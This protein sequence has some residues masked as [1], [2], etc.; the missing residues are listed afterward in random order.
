MDSHAGIVL[1]GGRSTRMG[2]PKASLEWH[3]STLVR[4]VAG[5]VARGVGGPVVVV[6]A[7]R[8][9]L[10][11]LP[12]TFEVVEDAEE[13]LGPL[14]GLSAGLQALGGRSDVA[15]VSSTDV[16]MLHPAFVRR[17]VSEVTDQ[18]D[19]CVPY[20]RGFRQPLSGAYRV[21]LAPL[22]AALV[23]ASRLRPAD[24]LEACRWTQLGD[25]AL[26]ADLELRRLDPE[27]DSVTN[28]NDRS[29]YEAARRKPAPEVSV[30]LSDSLRQAGST[31]LV[32]TRAATLGGATE[33]MRLQLGPLVVAT[34]NGVVVACDPELPLVRG[35]VLALSTSKG[36]PQGLARVT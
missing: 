20:V 27:L 35:D 18:F 6:R 2:Y 33:A 12:D 17:V 30:E 9:P 11:R 22:V 3:G 1:A 25:E 29:D 31:A 16:P 7:P 34:L 19:A 24:L 15:Y 36:G 28:L 4:R 21:S 23:A 26:L 13:G 8:Q 14:G 32:M 5:I 10:P